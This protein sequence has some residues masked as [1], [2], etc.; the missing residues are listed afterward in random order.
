M[1]YSEVE[2]FAKNSSALVGKIG[3]YTYA[4]L[5][6]LLVHVRKEAKALVRADCGGEG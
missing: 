4:N 3:C 2:L 1:A 5:F 6:T